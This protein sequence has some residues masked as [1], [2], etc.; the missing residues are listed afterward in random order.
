MANV[1]Q[2]DSSLIKAVYEKLK[3]STYT[4][5]QGMEDYD[6]SMSTVRAI[7]LGQYSECPEPIDRRTRKANG[8][9]VLKARG[10]RIDPE[11]DALLDKWCA[12]Y[13]TS[14]SGLVSKLIMQFAKTKENK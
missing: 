7:G 10:L 12:E 9:G 2:L 3:D 13:K 1:Q 4:Y 11:A 14:R 8:N 6:I 5:Q